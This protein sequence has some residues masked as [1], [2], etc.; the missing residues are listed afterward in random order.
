MPN[1]TPVQSYQDPDPPNNVGP[2]KFWHT[3]T[4]TRHVRNAADTAWI[5]LVHTDDTADGAI[6]ANRLVKGHT[7]GTLIVGTLASTAIVGV[8]AE[9]VAKVA[10]NRLHL[11]SGYVTCVAAEPIIAGARIKCADNGRITGFHETALLDTEMASS[12]GTGFANQ[13]ANDGVEFLSDSALDVSV[14][15]TFIGTTTGGHT[16]VVE[17]ASTDAT[18]GTTAAA[19]VKVNWGV[20]CG[21]EKPVTV[22]TITVREASADAAIITLAPAATSSGVVSVAAASQGTDGLAA[23]FHAGGASTKEVAVKYEP[24]TGA[25]D[26]YFANALNGTNAVAITA[27]NLIKKMY[28]GDVAGA[29]TV[30]LHTNAT[31]DS[32]LTGIV[33]GKAVSDF[34]AGSTGVAYIVP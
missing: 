1:A 34:T 18:D 3:P 5:A 24:A 12:V 9:N 30:T 2:G 16:V 14:P 26:A 31:A 25:A 17:T 20:L 13:P 19:T 11:A 28:V 8:N 32:T 7:D 33:V 29:S 6:P 27:S 23:Y 15:I 22:G 21:I 4:N 10:G